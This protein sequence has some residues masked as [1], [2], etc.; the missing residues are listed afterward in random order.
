MTLGNS[1]IEQLTYCNSIWL[2]LKESFH[3]SLNSGSGKETIRPPVP[4]KF[5][6]FAKRGEAHHD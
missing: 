2:K 3:H 5:P 4:P 6:I 1:E